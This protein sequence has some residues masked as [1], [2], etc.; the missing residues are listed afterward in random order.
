MTAGNLS[1]RHLRAPGRRWTAEESAMFHRHV[2]GGVSGAGLALMYGRSRAAVVAYAGELGITISAAATDDI[3]SRY[4]LVVNTCADVPSMVRDIIGR[5]SS[6]TGISPAEIAGKSRS[7]KITFARHLA[8]W[9]V[10]KDTGLTLT[11]IGRAFGRD[12]TTIIHATR[13]INSKTGENV[14]G[15]GQPP[16]S[17]G[18]GKSP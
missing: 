16:R 1:Y 15:L 5:V 10:A 4:R 12:H 17:A 9:T 14:R 7:A 11:Q 18:K 13:H 8:M 2:S 6:V 3:V